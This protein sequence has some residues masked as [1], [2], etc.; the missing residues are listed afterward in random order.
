MSC[1]AVA[2]EDVGTQRNPDGAAEAADN[3]G[4]LLAEPALMAL[5]VTLGVYPAQVGAG[6]S[7]IS[8]TSFLL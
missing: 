6:S 3:T 8:I 4:A 7:C 5:S 1:G 2:M